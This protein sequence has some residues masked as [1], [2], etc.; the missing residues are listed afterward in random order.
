MNKILGHVKVSRPFH[1][2]SMS[3]RHSPTRAPLLRNDKWPLGRK[4]ERQE[5]SAIF[6]NKV[7]RSEL[8]AGDLRAAVLDFNGTMTDAEDLRYEVH[9]AMAPSGEVQAGVK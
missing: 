3:F 5:G 4:T 2:R 8:S 9:F 7:S 1:A 6:M